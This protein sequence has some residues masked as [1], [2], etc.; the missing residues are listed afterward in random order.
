MM[1][2]LPAQRQLNAL[3]ADLTQSLEWHGRVVVS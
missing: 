2:G 1:A 3:H